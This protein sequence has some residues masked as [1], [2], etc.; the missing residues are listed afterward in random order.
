METVVFATVKVGVGVRSKGGTNMTGGEEIGGRASGSGAVTPGDA[1]VWDVDPEGERAGVAHNGTGTGEAE[2][3]SEG[4]GGGRRC[5]EGVHTCGMTV[6]G[7]DVGIGAG[8]D[9]GIGA[10][11]SGTD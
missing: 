10:G 2:T 11:E 4:G 9:V 1:G 7:N 8:N 5:G 6:V 3:V